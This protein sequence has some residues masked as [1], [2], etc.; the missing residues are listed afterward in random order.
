[1]ELVAEGLVAVERERAGGVTVAAPELGAQRLRPVGLAPDR[2]RRIARVARP[3]RRIARQDPL[4][5]LEVEREGVGAHRAGPS[6]RAAA[7]KARTPSTG[8]SGR[9]PWPTVSTS[10][11]AA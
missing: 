5:V 2:R 10:P 3:V 4:R 7:V 1:A 6:A 11:R 8:V 9:Q